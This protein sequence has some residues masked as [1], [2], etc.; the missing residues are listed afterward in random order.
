MAEGLLIISPRRSRRGNEMILSLQIAAAV[1]LLSA[2]RIDAIWFSMPDS[3]TK[4]MSEEIQ[5]H[6]V[7]V[8]DYQVIHNDHPDRNLTVSA[9]VTSP[10]GTNVYHQENVTS[11]QFAFTTTDSGSY[12][13]CFWL[14]GH[15]GSVGASLSLDWKTGIAAKDWESLAKKENIEGIELELTKL[16]GV[17]EAIHDNLSYLK[18]MEAD[19]REVSERTNARVAWFSILSL[20]LCISVSVLQLWHLKYFFQKK[21]LI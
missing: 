8:G 6:T 1:M 15:P 7:V 13:A 19:M 4:C 3:G 17:V 12:L 11:G 14:D 18:K 2:A 16:E 21:K 9:K 20:G 10:Y 5:A